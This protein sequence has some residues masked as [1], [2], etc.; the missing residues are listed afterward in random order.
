[1]S[2]DGYFFMEDQKT[3]LQ[4]IG[5]RQDIE[6]LVSRFYEKVQAN[7]I[8]APHFSHV[9]W[10]THLPIM[11]SFWASMILGEQTYRG[12]PFTKHAS[13][14]LQPIH[15]DEWISLFNSTVDELF[16]GEKATEIKDRARSIAQVF[17]HKMNL[18][19]EQL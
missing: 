3:I 19:K 1:M 7:K 18:L 9:N 13:L 4:D 11:H 6:L 5:T 15:F 10:E 8:L 17:Q 12:A 14:P 2:C 16:Q